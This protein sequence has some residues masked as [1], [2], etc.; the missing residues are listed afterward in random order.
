MPTIVT[1]GI[2]GCG[3]SSTLNTLA[4]D[5]LKAA[6][7]ESAE[8][9]SCTQSTSCQNCLWR[10]RGDVIRL[11]DTPG[12]SDSNG[13]DSQNIADMMEQ[14]K[15]QIQ[16]VHTFL[17][18]MD[19]GPSRSGVRMAEHMKAMLKLFSQCFG[20]DFLRNAMICFT[21]WGHSKRDEMKRNR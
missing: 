5:E 3:K 14:L 21:N 9:A 11:V 1:I 4:G 13:K 16:H 19:G 15:T 17:I 20:H 18:V 12:L 8:P 7:Q 10:G 2:T 6:F